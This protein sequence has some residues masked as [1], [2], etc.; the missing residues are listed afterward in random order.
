MKKEEK[1]KKEKKEEKKE[2]IEEKKQKEEKPEEMKIEIS[3][4]AWI[5]IGIIAVVLIAIFAIFYFSK[6]AGKFTYNGIEFRKEYTGSILF[7]TAYV[8]IID[9]YGKQIGTKAIDFR[10]DPR[11]LEDISVDTQGKIKFV[12]SK[13]VYITYPAVLN[14]C[15]YNQVA[16]ANLYLFLYNANL[17]VN[18]AVMENN[19]S[20]KQIPYVTC[21]NHQNNT[22]I[23]FRNGNFTGIKQTAENCYELTAKDCDILKV[24]EKFELVV[25]EQY[26]DEINQILKS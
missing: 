21:Q 17:K 20:T 16:G 3:K 9:V 25:L 4:E 11:T 19:Q 7:Y 5:T 24:M 10:N 2:N 15:E 26:M 13:T 12:S 8:P 23:E 14:A 18:T 1:Q 6:S 22:V